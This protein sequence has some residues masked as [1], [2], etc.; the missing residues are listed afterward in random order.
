MINIL[1][2]MISINRNSTMV[3][4]LIFAAAIV[5][6]SLAVPVEKRRVSYHK[7]VGRRD[8]FPEPKFPEPPRPSLIGLLNVTQRVDNFNPSNLDTWEQRYYF[9]NYY[10]TPGSPIFLFLAGEWEISDYRLTY[11]LMYDMAADLNANIFYLEHRYY[12]QSRPTA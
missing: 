2:D 5:A 8:P 6:I 12:G 3:K 9:N 4:L 11:S 10:Y 7:L 1:I